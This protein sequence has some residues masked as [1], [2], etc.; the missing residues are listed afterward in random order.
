MKDW[1]PESFRFINALMDHSDFLPFVQQ[2]WDSTNV[3][4]NKAFIIKEKL[5]L[6]KG[7]LR[8]WNKEVFGKVD[9]NI[10]SHVGYL[11][12]LDNVLS[13]GWDGGVVV[14]QREVSASLWKE[15]HVNESLLAQKSRA[16]WIKEG[17]MNSKYFHSLMKYR[18]RIC[19]V[20]ILRD[21]GEMVED[22]EEV[23]LFVK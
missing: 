21:N 14:N 10:D 8:G 6:L 17:D 12:S 22:F 4:G 23:K 3:I 16:K 1:G 15:I 19:N 13:E 7:S 2:C 5:K 20:V 18:R 11:N 9:L